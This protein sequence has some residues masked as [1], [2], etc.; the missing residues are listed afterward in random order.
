[1]GGLGG[2]KVLVEEVVGSDEPSEAWH[3]SPLFA[4]ATPPPPSP[5][6]LVPT[7]RTVSTG[8][9]RQLPELVRQALQ[10]LDG[11]KKDASKPEP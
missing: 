11:A 1:M 10:P 2:V 7:S 5:P 3:V 8:P 9:P 4:E 6:G